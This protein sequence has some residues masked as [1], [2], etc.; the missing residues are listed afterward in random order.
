MPDAAA[1]SRYGV[2]APTPLTAQAAAEVR[3]DD[4]PVPGAAAVEIRAFP[5]V[6]R[7]MTVVVLSMV[8]GAIAA[9]VT[10]D[11]AERTVEEC[12][13]AQR[14]IDL[15]AQDPIVQNILRECQSQ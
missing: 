8:G 7:V 14:I 15:G 11:A 3:T 4:L 1:K 2:A 12:L 13:A 6:A 9:S 10:D 5:I